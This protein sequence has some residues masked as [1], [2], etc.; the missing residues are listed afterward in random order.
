V[1]TSRRGDA[2]DLQCNQA[3]GSKYNT[4]QHTDTDTQHTQPPRYRLSTRPASVD[5]FS[6]PFSLLI[7]IA[8]SLPHAAREVNPSLPHCLIP[9]PFG[10]GQG[11]KKKK[12][13]KKGLWLG[14]RISALGFR[15]F[16]SG[17]SITGI[18]PSVRPSVRSSVC[19]SALTTP[20]P[21][22]PH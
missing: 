13:K 16:R 19:P 22:P 1:Q 18:H 4:T 7:A 17:P 9:P 5:T 14:A 12:K 6:R 3:G 2:I 15:L 11:Q 21:T 10:K 8:C 20:P